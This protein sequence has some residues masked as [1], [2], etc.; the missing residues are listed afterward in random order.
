M[1]SGVCYILPEQVDLDQL[2]NDTVYNL[3]KLFESDDDDSPFNASHDCPYKSSEEFY[4]CLGTNK[5]SYVSV[6]VRSISGK[7][8]EIC[9][10]L[11][12]DSQGNP[13]DFLSLQ[14]VW[15]IPPNVCFTANGYH[16]LVYNTRDPK[17]LSPN[18]G[19]SG[20]HN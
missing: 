17:G 14:E 19:G 8:D 18:I 15:N 9:N 2:Q 13:I 10:F 4:K 7:W 20:P 3:T 6:N 5:I 1:C 16:P 11:G 12:G